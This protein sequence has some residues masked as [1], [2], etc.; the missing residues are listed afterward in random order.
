MAKNRI[1]IPT[2][3]S[4]I[5]YNPVRVLPHIYFYNGLKSC[6]PYYIQGYANGDTGSVVSNVQEF[7]PY[8]DNYE[9]NN[10]QSGSRSLLFFNEPSFYGTTPT[11]SLYTEYW[12]KYIDLLYNPRTRLFECSAIIPLADYFKM[13]LNDIV[14]WR[15]NYYHLRAINDY[16]LKNGECQLQLLG[17]ILGDILPDILPAIACDFNF[18]ISRSVGCPYIVGDLA[19]GGVIAY[20]LEPG[21]PEYDS[22][23]QKGLVATIADIST[24]S[25]WGCLGTTITGAD[26]VAIGTGN[27]NTIDIMADCATAGIAARISG[28]LVEGGFSDWYLPSKDE[29]NK[30]YLNKVAI[31]GFAGVF[32]WSSTEFSSNQAW[33]Q[34][35]DD[36]FQ[37]QLN[38]SSET[39]VRAI[40]SFTCP[41]T[42]TTTTTTTTT[43]L[44][45]TTTTTL[46]PT[47]TTT[48]AP[49]TTTTTISPEE[50]CIE[51]D[52]SGQIQEEFLN[53][54]VFNL[55]NVYTASYFENCIAANAP[56]DITVYITGSASGGPGGDIIYSLLIASG[57]HFGTEDVYTRIF[58]GT[59][60][61]DRVSE[62]YTITVGPIDPTYPTCSCPPL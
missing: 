55:Y 27:Q 9:G 26:G 21:D 29:L 58:T 53:C 18:S 6:E 48:L 60:C 39:N 49:T 20:I 47:T 19:E 17:P 62:T 4:S 42:P 51:I 3:I 44:S 7:F 41:A 61:E 25:I 11:G 46:A 8:F 36:G 1:Y 30:L 35:F 56:V 23:Q 43:T 40:R 34:N 32:Y 38:K 57:S 52:V 54:G 5:N 14:E 22:N 15:G 28:D 12:S 50:A 13:E 37:I 2:F 24:G 16:N 33:V 59:D 31:G 45:P 10:P